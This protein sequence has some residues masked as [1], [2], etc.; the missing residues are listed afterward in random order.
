M[1]AYRR[2][3]RIFVSHLSLCNEAHFTKLKQ[4]LLS[5]MACLVEGFR[6]GC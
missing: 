5:S 6:M 4:T 1:I 3:K 2:K